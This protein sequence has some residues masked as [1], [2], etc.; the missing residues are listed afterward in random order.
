MWGVKPLALASGQ[1]AHLLDVKGS[2]TSSIRVGAD[3][4]GAGRWVDGWG[5][6]A[7]PGAGKFTGESDVEGETEGDVDD[8]NGSRGAGAITATVAVEDA[9][10]GGSPRGTS[11]TSAKTARPATTVP[12]PRA[13]HPHRSFC[14]DGGSLPIATR[15]SSSVG[16]SSSSAIR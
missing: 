10:R 1:A 8:G 12:P 6:G 7:T 16:G 14:L 2:P 11:K 4:G 13:I 5:V 9:G 3:R 15:I